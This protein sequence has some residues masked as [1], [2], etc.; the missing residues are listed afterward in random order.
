MSDYQDDDLESPRPHRPAEGVRIIGAEEAARALEEGQAEG[1][2]PEDAPR[3]GDVP[4]PPEGPRPGYRFP[5]PESVD[6][7]SA[8]P[9]PPVAP[10]G[11]EANAGDEG[12]EDDYDHDA[13]ASGPPTQQVE[14]PHW[15]EPPSGEVPRI[16]AGEDGEDEDLGAWS[17]LA[18]GQGPRWRD[19]HAD[20]EDA[21]FDDDLL[22]DDEERLGALDV[23]RTEHSDLFSFDDPEP[24]TVYDDE[25]EPEPARRQVTTPIRTRPAP[26][27]ASPSGGSRDMGTAIGIG[28]ALAI[29]ALICFKAGPALTMVL[30]TAIITFAAVE[31]FAVLRRA[32][33]RPATLL[34]LT[35][36]VSIMLAAYNKGETA[37]PLVV[38]MVVITSF[39]WYLF[40]VVKARPTVNVAATLL[41]FMWVGFLGSYSALILGFPNRH[42]VAALLGAVLCTV[43]YDVGGLFFGSQMGSRPLMPAISPNKTVEG[44][45]G[46]VAT[47]IILGALFGAMVD[48][49]N[50]KRGFVL[51]LVVALMAPLGDLAESMIK[52]DIGIKDMGSILPGHGGVLDRFDAMLFILPATYYLVKLL[53]L[54]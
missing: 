33:Y 32:G 29:V 4:R 28:V 15:T 5:L 14:M 50:V 11:Y 41:G 47:S 39:L 1:R 17:G 25:P 6:P 8:V 51:G 20:W 35:A 22:G 24:E 19:S 2:R 52:R 23:N 18:S 3:F 43:G 37:L 49:W 34:G 42:G 7:A 44:L 40:D 46:G 12:F 10:G 16:L 26:E 21:D 30:A 27:Y 54:G 48:P 9:R 45:M 13:A 38:A 31:V 53:K 36:T